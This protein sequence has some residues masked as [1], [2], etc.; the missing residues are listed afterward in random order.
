MCLCACSTCNDQKVK[1]NEGIGCLKKVSSVC[2]E[3]Y[4]WFF[5]DG[6][7]RVTANRKLTDLSEPLGNSSC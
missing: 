1:E 2:D 7:E 6:V 4:L 5:L 3:C